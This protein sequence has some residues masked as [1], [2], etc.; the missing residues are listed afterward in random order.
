MKNNIKK[1]AFISALFATAF[2]PVSA[3][4]AT[5]DFAS[6]L[7]VLNDIF[8]KA[9]PLIIGFAVIVFFW[10]V[11]KFVRAAD[12]PEQRAEGRKFMVYGIV[13]IFVLFSFWGL[14]NLIIS[15]VLGTVDV[16]SPTI[17]QVK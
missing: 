13:S 12:Q 16:S 4:A 6:F 14:V 17:P 7:G 1:N 3:F 2:L 11:V 10:G 8:A 5:T 9:I 15:T